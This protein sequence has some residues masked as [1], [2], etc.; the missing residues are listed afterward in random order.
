MVVPDLLYNLTATAKS[1]PSTLRI[2]SITI[3]GG[4]L[5]AIVEPA[6]IKKTLIPHEEALKYGSFVKD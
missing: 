5:R 4:A 6:F 1:F 3:I 2:L